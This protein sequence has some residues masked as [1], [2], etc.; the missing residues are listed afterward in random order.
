MFG[1]LGVR[2]SVASKGFDPSEALHALKA[3]GE[4]LLVLWRT[5]KLVEK[6]LRHV[7]VVASFR[8]S[9]S[10]RLN[11]DIPTMLN[12]KGTS[13]SQSGQPSAEG[14]TFP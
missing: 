8:R 1:L 9:W 12:E 2:Q 13:R 11:V 14:I 4:I 3:I 6:R 5:F 7:G 10:V